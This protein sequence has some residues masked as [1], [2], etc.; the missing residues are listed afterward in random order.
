MHD[1]TKNARTQSLDLSLR[2]VGQY[3]H[4]L[5]GH[6]LSAERMDCRFTPSLNPA[7]IPF[8]ATDTTNA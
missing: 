7:L 5:Q 1:K 4:A 3:L 8:P 2:A 6:I